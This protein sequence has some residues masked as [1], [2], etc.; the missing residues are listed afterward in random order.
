M[1]IDIEN[2]FLGRCG[3]RKD[4]VKDVYSFLLHRDHILS[5]LNNLRE[6]DYKEKLGSSNLLLVI[7]EIFS[8]ETKRPKTFT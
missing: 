4:K 1:N 7:D 6:I 2:V 5:R 3:K 8:K